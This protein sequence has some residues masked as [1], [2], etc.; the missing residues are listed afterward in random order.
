MRAAP[1]PTA[2][3]VAALARSL[4]EDCLL[5][6]QSLAAL[7]GV[8]ADQ[9]EEVLVTHLAETRALQQR[10]AESARRLTARRGEVDRLPAPLRED[11][12]ACVAD[13]RRQLHAAGDACARLTAD[14][15]DDLAAIRERLDG[16]RQGG[17]MLRSYRQAAR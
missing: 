16:I 2:P 9:A 5:L 14:V 10:I 4:R 11:A 13:A 15:T 17:R 8:P 1:P 7:G 6:A 3:D 12:A